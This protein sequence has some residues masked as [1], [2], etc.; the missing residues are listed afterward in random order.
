M[1]FDNKTYMKKELKKHR[2]IL[3]GLVQQAVE[4]DEPL[5]SFMIQ[6]QEDTILAFVKAI[7]KEI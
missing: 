7:N 1:T 3:A 4:N 2:S 6:K 5:D